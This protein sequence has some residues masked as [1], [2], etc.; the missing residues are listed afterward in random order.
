[1]IEWLNLSDEDRLIS[2][3]QASI[4]SDYASMREQMIYDE[5]SKDFAT[6][7]ERLRVLLQTFRQAGQDKP[8]GT[9]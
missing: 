8:G 1:M 4:E 2:I 7:I 5:R 6:I 3:Q 9:V